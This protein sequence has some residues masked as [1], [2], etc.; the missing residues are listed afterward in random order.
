MWGVENTMLLVFVC[1]CLRTPCSRAALCVRLVVMAAESACCLASVFGCQPTLALLL[2]PAQSGA[3]RGACA[4]S[5]CLRVSTSS[6]LQFTL[7][8][9][10]AVR[11]VLRSPYPVTILVL[12]WPL[13]IK[14]KLHYSSSCD[15]DTFFLHGDYA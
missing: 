11:Q 12:M 8:I 4:G 9:H 6:S 3:A 15:A 10:V 13:Q 5:S 1:I 14:S 2:D 7:R